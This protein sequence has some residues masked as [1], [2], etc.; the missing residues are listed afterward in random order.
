MEEQL[1]TQTIMRQM[2]M[3]D[4]GSEFWLCARD[5]VGMYPKGEYENPIQLAR[6]NNMIGIE[7]FVFDRR[8][9]ARNYASWS[10][11]VCP[12]SAGSQEELQEGGLGL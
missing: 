4:V 1:I 8:T 3:V 11:E 9:D 10:K 6:V 12:V 7:M 2:Q 5:G